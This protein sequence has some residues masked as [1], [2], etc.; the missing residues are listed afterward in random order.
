M[1]HVGKRSWGITYRS[2]NAMTVHCP[3]VLFR[4]QPSPRL[5][6]ASGTVDHQ[7]FLAMLFTFLAYFVAKENQLCSAAIG[8]ILPNYYETCR[9]RGVAMNFLSL[10]PD[11]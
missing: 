6:W 7:F 3:G 8:S 4:V 1:K 5:P 10:A 2:G 9:T 11:S